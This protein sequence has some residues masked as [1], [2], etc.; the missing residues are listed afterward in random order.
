MYIFNILLKTT[1][2]NFDFYVSKYLEHEN[3]KSK[4]YMQSFKKI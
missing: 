3:M 4:M 1:S 2:P